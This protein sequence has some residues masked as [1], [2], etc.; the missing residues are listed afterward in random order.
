MKMNKMFT[1]ILLP[2]FLMVWFLTAQADEI[3]IFRAQ[4]QPSQVAKGGQGTIT[5]QYEIVEGYHISDASSGIFE[6]VPKSV[7]GIEFMEP[8]F[9]PP[10]EDDYGNFYTGKVEVQIPFQVNLSASQGVLEFVFELTIQPCSEDGGICYPPEM[11]EVQTNVEILSRIAE[12]QQSIP[13]EGISGQVSRALEKGSLLAFLFVFLGGILT[14]LTPCVYPM[15]PI[16]IAVI[17]AQATGGK[18][19]GFV[20]SLFYVLGLAVTFSTLGFIAARTGSFRVIHA[21]FSGHYSHCVNFLFY[22][23]LSFGRLRHSNACLIGSKIS[24][25]KAQGFFWS[26]PDRPSSRSGCQSLHQSYFG[27]HFDLGGQICL[28]HSGSG[29]AFYFCFGSGRLVYTHWHFLRNSEKSAQIRR[30]DGN[31]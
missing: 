23:P 7:K 12:T 6:V 10:E 5:I 30:V 26:I 15:I 31:G 11:H 25:E 16:T 18:L 28:N 22:G 14:S 21:T 29:I 4:S 9:P 2:G 27:C 13:S 1:L 3:V 19:K 8:I 17:G 20:L 24:G